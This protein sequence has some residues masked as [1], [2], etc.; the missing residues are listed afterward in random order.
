MLAGIVIEVL[1]F[2][3]DAINVRRVILVPPDYVGR[4]VGFSPAGHRAATTLV[5]GSAH[6][7]EVEVTHVFLIAH[8]R[9]RA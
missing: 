4:M 1:L 7:K 8:T 6:V 2:G 9:S 5:I 3:E